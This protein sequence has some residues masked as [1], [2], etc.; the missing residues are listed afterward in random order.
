ML[1]I[2]NQ[3]NNI[4]GSRVTILNKKG[5]KGFSPRLQ[6]WSYKRVLISSLN[7]FNLI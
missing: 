7:Q 1:P 6:N 5:K 4:E 2:Q 3:M